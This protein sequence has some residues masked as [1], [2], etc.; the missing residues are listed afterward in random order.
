LQACIFYLEAKVIVKNHLFE[1]IKSN[2]YARVDK[3]MEILLSDTSYSYYR[4]KNP[5]DKDLGDFITSPEI[6]Q[7]FGEVI[8]VWLY[9]QFTISSFAKSSDRVSIIEFGAGTGKLLKDI[10]KT[11]KLTD[12]YQKLDIYICEINSKLINI[13]KENLMEYKVCWIE[14]IVQLKKQPSFFIGNEF[15]DALPIRQ[16]ILEKTR[17]KEIVLRSD[18]DLTKLFWDKI[19]V[20]DELDEYFK[21]EY[22]KAKDGAV[23]EESEASIA[24]IKKISEFIFKYSG[25]GLFI[26]YAYD[27]EPELRNSAQFTPTL[28]S[29]YR[30]KFNP[31]LDQIGEADIT[32]HV[33][34]NKLRKVAESSFIKSSKTITQSRLLDS[35]GIYERMNE[36]ISKNPKMKDILLNQYQRLTSKNEMGELFKAILFSKKE[37]NLFIF[38]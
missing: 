38:E 24:F 33:D 36:L 21:Y 29:I 12:L 34:F 11:L 3:F 4:C 22:S 27:I 10:L 14:D 19:D 35:C 30:H 6:S 1:Y 5:L 7:M 13:Q 15:L 31:V 17:W 25:F 26:D 9:Y 8:G 2:G 20:K 18:P 28:Q 37:E 23:I 32:A 16:Y